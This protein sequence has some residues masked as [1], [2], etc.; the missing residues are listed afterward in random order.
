[1]P[2]AAR[3][4]VGT[5]T[6]FPVPAPRSVDRRTAGRAMLLAPLVA[7]LLLVPV[8]VVLMLARVV[9]LSPLVQ[10]VLAVA[11]LALSTRALHLDG[12]ADTADG[13][14]A[15]YDPE[16]ALEVMR[17]GDVGPAG[18]STLVVTLALQIACG[19]TLLATTSGTT[20]AAVAV[21]ASRLAITFACTRGFRA[22]RPEGLGSLV[23]ESV[24][25]SG[26]VGVALAV[27]AL[28]TATAGAAEAPWWSGP[29]VVCAA[30]LAA[31]TVALRV[32]RRIGGITGDTLGA[33]VEIACATTLLVAAA[34]V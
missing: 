5:L 25:R 22:A 30:L 9:D 15:S 23:A 21:V 14:T 27:A 4:A 6:A 24:S 13:L 2:D 32:V 20:V 26:L 34:I 1:M 18:A 31:A 3:L 8:A 28:A 12:L 7:V 19:T 16:R 17:T 33:V 29:V 11:V 10:A